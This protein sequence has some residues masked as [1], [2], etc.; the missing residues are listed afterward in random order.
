MKGKFIVFD[1]IDGSGKTTQ[2]KLLA[3]YLRKKGFKVAVL[4]EPTRG[5]YG[6]I[7][8]KLVRDKNASNLN[9]E[10]WLRLFDLDRKENVEK[11]ILPKLKNSFIILQDRY[12]YST[13][14]YQLPDSKDKWSSYI[15]KYP[16]PDLTFIF[17]LPVEDAIKRL[18]RRYKGKKKNTV[19]EKA[20]RLKETRKNFSAIAGKFKLK[21]IDALNP[22]N[23]ISSLIRK[24]VEKM[25]KRRKK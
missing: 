6:T 12:Y 17:D 2:I 15:K 16:K 11:N 8:N 9:K 1:G 5:K 4:F 22:V 3:S 20:E 21:K 24:D 23:K 25:L 13:L 19:F 10:Y 18:I 7:I 14:A